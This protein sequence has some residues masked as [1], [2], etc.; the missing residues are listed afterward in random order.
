MSKLKKR[1][2]ICGQNSGANKEELS[3]F[4]DDLVSPDI[5]SVIDLPGQ[6]VK[7]LIDNDKITFRAMSWC[8]F[9]VIWAGDI[10][11]IRAI[12]PAEAGVGDIILYKTARRAYAHRLIG[13]YREK[14]TLYIVTDGEKGSKNNRS[15]NADNRNG[16]PADNILGKVTE[17]KRGRA[18]FKADE[19]RTGL[20]SLIKGRL[21][22]LSWVL[23]HNIKQF[24]ARIFIGLQGLSLYRR[25]FRKL[26]N[27][28]ASF[29]VGVPL[30][31]DKKS[32][33]SFCF[34]R[35][36]DEFLDRWDKNPGNYRI[37]AKLG[38]RPV[39]NISLFFDIDARSRKICLLHN[40]TVRTPFR[41]AGIGSGL[42][43]KTLYLCDKINADDIKV[44]LSEEDN[45][46]RGLFSRFGFE[47]NGEA[48]A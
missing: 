14:D 47:I 20:R 31:K 8:M 34:Y 4:G 15:D 5:L 3:A 28:K 9:P 46:G 10:L 33:I 7:A 42:L 45:V 12:E 29:F 43:E 41:G 1:V 38:K 37:L 13:T 44:N 40:F 36:F 17:I 26:I 2:I 32:A 6:I 23:S 16:V 27:N 48:D 21:K 25:F 30:I 18:R 24:I 35:E 39:G 19:P 22:L 11:K